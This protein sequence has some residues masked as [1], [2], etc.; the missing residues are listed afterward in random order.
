M[1]QPGKSIRTF[2]GSKNFSESCKF[3]ETLEF[4]LHHHGKGFAYV[5][6][7]PGI[8]FYLQD[9]YNKDWCENNMVFLEVDNLEAYLAKIKSLNLP[10]KF[11]GVKVSEIRKDSWGDE[12]FIHDPA[13]VLWHIG[14]FKT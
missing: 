3:Y 13:G 14:V 6:I 11:P 5:S 8:G 9:F 4:E 7:S 12:F 2:I 10:D 1:I